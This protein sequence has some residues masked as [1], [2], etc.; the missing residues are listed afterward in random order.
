MS[1][2]GSAV[3]AA[4]LLLAGCRGRPLEVVYDL[5]RRAPVAELWSE[6][7]VLLFGT[8]SSGPSLPEG[9]YREAE[10]SG[11][12]LWS[13]GEAEVA[14]RFD[15]IAPRA[16]VVDV[17][18]YE[19]VE[20]QSVE[21]RLNGTVVDRFRLADLRSRYL[22]TLPAAS[23]RR[24]E[25]RLRFV[26]AKTASPAENDPG[27]RDERRL[28]AAFYSLT[29]GPAGDAGLEDLLRRDAPRP[30]A[31]VET[32]GIPSLSLVGPAAVRFALRLPEAAEL[33]FSPDLP[34]AARAAAGAASFRVTLK[35]EDE[36]GKERELWARVLR[37][38]DERPGEVA[39]R[40]PGKAGRIARI[41]LFVGAVDGRRFAWGT[42]TAPRILGRGGADSLEPGPRAPKED[43][44]AEAIRRG[45]A[46]ANVVFVILDAAR[47]R[48]LG[49]Y[50]YGRAT[51]PVI[52]RIAAEGVVFDRAYTPAV[53]TLGAMSSVW[54]S[55]YP[56]RH[57]GDVSFSS[58]LPRDRLTLAEVLT[59]QGIHTVGFV[60]TAVPGGFN[61]FDR[62]FAEFHEVWRELGSRAD[63]FRQVIP[64]WLA[65]NAAQR[66]FAYIHYREPHFPYDPEPPF[67][68][69]FGPDGPI[70]KAARRDME[71]FRD[72][73]QGGR[74]FSAQ[75]RE[76]LV[77]L[78]DGNLAYVDREIG[79]LRE[80]LE[81][82]G[83]WDRTLLVVAADHGEALF[84]HGW[85]GHNVQVYDESSR[86]P[87]VL[88]FPGGDFPRGVRVS[89]LVDLLDIAPTIADVFG[90]RHRGG[91]DREFQ[92]R[93][94]LPVV[95]GARGK[96]LVVSR[97]VWDRP[98][99]ALRDGRWTYLFD[100]ANG[101]QRLFDG[102]AD[103]GET[104]N[105]AASHPLRTSWFRE[106]LH[107]WMRTVFRH[108]A[109][110]PGPPP[111]MSREQ[112]EDLK[113]LGYV[114]AGHTCPA[115]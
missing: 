39:V 88:R 4:A 48:Q 79:A 42:W 6:R 11:A 102:A 9:F 30:F 25:N 61:G 16:A 71:F 86:I 105:V 1:G 90:V 87:L 115:S 13:K 50:G 55:Q 49:T 44:R 58:P 95:A 108:G 18:P 12:F 46:R 5:A 27:N 82:A 45:L 81:A 62:G 78:Y 68:T 10:G 70:P 56:D 106:T 47:A 73:N 21:V 98:R 15:E 3:L 19:G 89:E 80:A 52:D 111:T 26:F 14:L 69:M 112:C 66:F 100:A 84:E 7:E 63:V 77:R 113:A 93:S 107:Q 72:V 67:D 28:A 24:G 20:E 114:A 53:Y 96:P 109:P 76:H 103:P 35:T 17:A 32:G 51:T 2:G 104:R 22:V 41:G 36:P 92:G 33:R 99:Y 31:V 91:A 97:T 64:P 60:A 54:T 101:E 23:Q 94:L 65:K 40:L 29:T 83:V 74:A 57:H 85:V 37:T 38:N 43:A 8:P 110:A 75:E 34:V 59:A